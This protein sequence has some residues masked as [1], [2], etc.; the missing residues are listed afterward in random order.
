MKYVSL[1]PETAAPD[2]TALESE[3]ECAADFAPARIGETRF[4]FKTGRKIYHIPLSQITR[5]FRRVELVN[6]RMGCCNQGLPMESVVVCGEGEKELAQIRLASERMGKAL[7][8]ALETACP[9][10]QIGYVRAPD[11]D[12][13]VRQV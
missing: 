8:S 13:A 4:F 12:G 9:N 11:Q 2:K 3:Y 5:C 7:L 10:A 1:Q 6:A